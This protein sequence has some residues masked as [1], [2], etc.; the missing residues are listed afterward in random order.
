M[1]IDQDP[2]SHTYERTV[3]KIFLN[4]PILIDQVKYQGLYVHLFESTF[5]IEDQFIS[6]FDF[7][8]NPPYALVTGSYG[9]QIQFTLFSENF[10][11]EPQAPIETESQVLHVDF[12]LQGNLLAGFMDG[13]LIVYNKPDYTAGTPI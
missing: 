4:F 8:M 13:D 7:D 3:E 9:K 5:P 1:D 10:A 2:G 12:N 6:D 11:L